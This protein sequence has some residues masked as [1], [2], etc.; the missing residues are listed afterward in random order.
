MYLEFCESERNHETSQSRLFPLIGLNLP[1]SEYKPKSLPIGP[2]FFRVIH[3]KCDPC[4]RSMAHL[5]VAD[6]RNG[7]R[8]WRVAANASYKQ[9]Q[10]DTV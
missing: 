2:N 8:I 3:I 5:Q 10:T 4:Q 7:F 9:S 6:V 1:P